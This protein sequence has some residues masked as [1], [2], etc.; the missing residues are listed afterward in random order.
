MF[1]ALS[2]VSVSA[3][4]DSGSSDCFIDSTFVNKYCV[5]TYSVT[6]LQLQLFDGTSNSMI[7]QAIDVSIRFANGKVTPMKFF[8]TPLDGSCAIVLGHNWLTQYNP[9]IDWVMGSIKFQMIEQSSPAPPS[10]AKD[11]LD[12]VLPVGNPTSDLL[13]ASDCQAPSIELVSPVAFVKAC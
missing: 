7:M 9:S 13:L 3:L 2:D 12:S 4:I 8:V 11:L 5:P 1:S 6:P 10:S